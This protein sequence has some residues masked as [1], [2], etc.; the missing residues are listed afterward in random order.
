MNDFMNM[1]FGMGSLPLLSNAKTRSISAENPTGMP[2]NG[3]KAVPGENS[4]AGW[5]GKGWKVRPCV[6]VK[7]GE[8]F[9]MAE[10]EGP[11]VIQHIWLTTAVKFHR[12]IVIRIYW[13][14]EESPSVECPLGDFFAVGH[15]VVY[16]VNSLP[17][18]VN[19]TGGFNCYWPMPFRKS[20]RITIENQHYENIPMF[21]YQVTYSLT[22]IPDNAAYFHAQ[23]R[24]TRTTDY[25]CPEHV[26]VDQVKGKGQY[27]G[28]FLAWVQMSDRWWGEGEVKF[29][30][31]GD[32]EYPTI[33]GTGTEDYFGGAWSFKDTYSTAFLGYPYWN[34]KEASVPKHSMYR[35]HIPD[36]IRFENELKVSVQA[37]G[38]YPGEERYYEPLTDDIASVA[39]W[40]QAEPHTKFPELLEAKDRWTR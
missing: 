10:I 35:W 40:Y 31:D 39:Y 16:N 14:N 27:V 33:C 29:Y 19:P 7:A 30:M 8:I 11:G 15:S 20:C 21:F 2:G 9:T 3:A 28:T 6:E 38:W 23:W 1:S 18:C 32:G 25:A 5:L 37:L 24:R 22:D 17:V 13:D 34:K 36:P 12:D 26:I 4:P